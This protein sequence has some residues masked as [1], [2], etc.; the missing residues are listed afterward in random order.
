MPVIYDGKSIRPAPLVSFSQEIQEVADGRRLGTNI[1]ATLTGQITATKTDDTET[2]IAIE[3]RLA[4]ILHK[5]VALRTLFQND[6]RIFEVQGYDGSDP[7]KFN[8]KV[9]S[10]VFDQGIWVDICNYTIVLEGN[11][12]D[13]ELDIDFSSIESASENWNFE[14]GE[15]PHTYRVSH[16][17][18]AKGKATYDADGNITAHAWELAKDFVQTQLALGMNSVTTPWSPISGA[19]MFADSAVE[20]DASNQYN[21]IITETVDELD[22]TYAAT[23]NYF[24][25]NHNYWEEYTVSVRKVSGEQFFGNSVSIQGTIHGLY[26]NL[27][28]IEAKLVNARSYWLSLEPA[29]IS[30]IAAYV[31]S[32]TLN[33]NPTVASADMNYN[34]GSISYNYEFNDRANTNNTL[35]TY[36]VSKQTSL[37][38][39]K[40]TVTIEGT[41]RGEQYL[42]EA[43]VVDLK[44]QRALTQYNIVKLLALSRCVAETGIP[45]LRAFPVSASMTPNKA[46]GSI[47][48]T[49]VFDNRV[50][51]SVKDESTVSTRYSR[52]DGKTY[53]TVDG[54]ITGYR[55]AHAADPFVA[56]DL[57]ERYN[58]AIAY[59]QGMQDNILG[60]AANYVDTTTV[61]PTAYS[62]Q[63]SH[64]PLAGTV[65]YNYEYNSMP[66]PCYP[67]AISE[68]LTI[69]DDASVPVIAILPVMG[70]PEGPIFQEIGT[71]KEKRRSLVMEIVIAVDGSMTN[72][73]L[74]S[75]QAPPLI[76]I[77]PYAPIA[78]IV[79]IE[80]DNT[81]WSPTS[82]RYTRNVTWVYQ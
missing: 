50:P 7:V 26:V 29:L 75:S 69:T 23:E 38:D 55:S 57:E 27:H 21:R 25:S 30:R 51:E 74:I 77:T 5:Q 9:K 82:G 79:Y 19:T 54:T 53:V 65:S 3:G 12:F 52:D 11:E 8:A 17:L 37:E 46:E 70:R 4:S 45:D 71:V 73:E 14:E 10:I 67:G 18:S 36:N 48:Y 80:Q 24:I 63:V 6:G 47:S 28:D 78:D 81:S 66:A 22:G 39:G 2:P 60:L 34:D 58:A 72:C 44:Y 40:T 15:G 20:P 56:N 61:N 33:P 59:F 43:F 13:D 76:D 1:T 41:I 62:K 32:V 35:E 42:N 64:N 31:P 68:I 49:Y 16:T